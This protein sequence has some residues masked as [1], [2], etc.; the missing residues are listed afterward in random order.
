MHYIIVNEAGASVYSA[1]PLGSE[2]FPQYDVGIKCRFHCKETSRSFS[3]LVKIDPKSIGVGQ[4]QHDMNQKRL[5]EALNGVV[6][7]CE[8][9]W[10][11]LKYGF[12]FSASVCCR[13]RNTVAKNI[14]EY[15][16]TNGSLQQKTI[17]RSKE[18]GPKVFGHY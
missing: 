6:E 8:S 1:S 14:V 16:E 9:S 17:I 13:I 4:Y 7:S 2:E 5:E 18:L 3:K 15:R 11:R 10:G 12:G